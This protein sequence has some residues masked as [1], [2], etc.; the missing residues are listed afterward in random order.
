M[1]F[2]QRKVAFLVLLISLF[3]ILG[4]LSLPVTHTPLY[5]KKNSK[6]CVCNL[7]IELDKDIKIDTKDSVNPDYLTN[8]MQQ[9]KTMDLTYTIWVT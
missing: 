5:F 6:Y 7:K 2:S 9:L 8:I 3:I 4:Y 1:N